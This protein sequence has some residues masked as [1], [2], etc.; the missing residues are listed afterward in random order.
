MTKRIE[1]KKSSTH[2]CLS[3]GIELIAPKLD[4]MIG[5]EYICDT[6]REQMMASLEDAGKKH[7]AF[8]DSALN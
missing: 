6:C 5:D 1:G 3:C 2:E 7:S 8:L 4:N